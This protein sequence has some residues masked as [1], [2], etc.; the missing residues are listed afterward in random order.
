MNVTSLA[1][2]VAFRAL[3][4]YLAMGE[5]SLFPLEQNFKP[6]Q[7]NNEEDL[8]PRR[9]SLMI[10][11]KSRLGGEATWLISMPA[12]LELFNDRNW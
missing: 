5:C 7:L 6:V 3:A 8:Q 1:M 4:F 10:Y 2:P 12:H 11:S 9:S